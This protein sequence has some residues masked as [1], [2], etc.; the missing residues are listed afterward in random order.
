MEVP[1][2]SRVLSCTPYYVR[3]YRLI[4]RRFIT[5][6]RAECAR[7]RKWVNCT[8]NFLRAAGRATFLSFPYGVVFESDLWKRRGSGSRESPSQRNQRGNRVCAR[9]LRLYSTRPSLNFE[10]SVKTEM[11]LPSRL[12][13][14]VVRL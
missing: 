9:G 11:R 14:E 10:A 12:A 2:N 4:C 13:R 7:R 3:I 5:P 6:P 8:R 1:A